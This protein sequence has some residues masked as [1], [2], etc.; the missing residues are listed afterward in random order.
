MLSQ[1]GRVFTPDQDGCHSVNRAMLVPAKAARATLA[2][3]YLKA[4]QTNAFHKHTGCDA[5]R[6]TRQIKT[7]ACKSM[8]NGKSGIGTRTFR[9]A[10]WSVRLH[11]DVSIQM[12][13][14][15]ICFLATVPAALVHALDFLVAP[16]RTLV[17]LC[18]W[19]WHERVDGGQWM[20]ALRFAI[21]RQALS[22]T[23][24]CAPTV[25]GRCT[26]ETIAGVGGPDEPWP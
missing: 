20:P 26:G 22:C 21:S 14:C 25:G 12:I 1:H 24:P 3:A 2:R 7:F 23:R 11:R 19:N 16:A 15:T 9:C 13:E 17:L 4:R 6:Q 10:L 5:M 8:K 18:A